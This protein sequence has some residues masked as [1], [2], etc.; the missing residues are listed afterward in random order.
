M[1]AAHGAG[2]DTVGE[3]TPIAAPCNDVRHLDPR[4]RAAKSRDYQ[5]SLSTGIVQSTHHANT[6]FLTLASPLLSCKEK[7]ERSCKI[8]AA[9]T[10]TTTP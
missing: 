5:W 9:D 3:A 7:L 4:P 2:L 10:Q 8:F 1:E 6:L